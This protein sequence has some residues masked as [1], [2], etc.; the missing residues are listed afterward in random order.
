MP[1][2][3]D[4]SLLQRQ[5]EE[6]EDEEEEEPIQAK[7]AGGQTAHVGPGLNARI[8]SM[9]GGGQPLTR[10]VRDFFEPRFGHDFS[11]VR[12]HTDA[13]ASEAA[14]SVNA[15]AFTVGKDVVFGAGQSALESMAGKKLIAHELTHVM[16]QGG[17]RPS[18][19]LR[20]TMIQRKPKEKKVEP[21]SVS[22]YRVYDPIGRMATIY[23]TTASSTLDADD[24]NI[25]EK[26]KH[27]VKLRLGKE[28]VQV[29]IFG[30]ADYRGSEKYNKGLTDRRAAAVAAEFADLAKN[31][32]FS[33]G[34]K[35]MGETEKFQRGK[36][37]EELSRYRRADIYVLPPAAPEFPKKGIK[38]IGAGTRDL[39]RI[40]SDC[41]GLLL[42]L[43]ADNMLAEMAGPVLPGK[44][45]LAA[46]AALLSML[47]SASVG[48]I[49]DTN[50][51][52]EGTVVGVYDPEH[53]GYQ[54]IDVGN[55]RKMEAASGEKKGLTACDTIMHE[56]FEAFTGRKA[57]LSGKPKDKTYMAAHTVGKKLEDKIRADLGL[58]PRSSKKGGL[59]KLGNLDKN[60]WLMLDSI[61]F[62]KGKEIYTQLNVIKFILGPL[63]I[64]PDLSLSQSGDPEV[65]ASH[66]VK[67][68]VTFKTRAEAVKIFNKYA[69]YF[70]YKSIK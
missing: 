60:T 1:K 15:R 36:T 67:G 61:L 29:R 59:I 11:G 42:G 33:F 69:S 54:R 20:A 14:K 64:K 34:V 56:V 13:R 23:F 31:P 57:V 22:E 58:P 27:D 12:V 38:V 6:P 19:S 47:R 8:N 45:S 44:T 43:D 41:T 40:L 49:I 62:Q 24:K 5:E 55:L 39:V 63:K 51:A 4:D 66:V 9:K 28:K 32:N 18:A 52:S 25:I 48:I 53:P 46:E 16:Q 70:G 30:F 26:V 2:L 50:P 3:I 68:E 17:A 10:S 35:G 65:V 7:Q 21:Q 37:S